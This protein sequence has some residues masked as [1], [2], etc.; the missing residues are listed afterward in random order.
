MSR[1]VRW[2][3]VTVLIALLVSSFHASAAH[4]QEQ[5]RSFNETGQTVSGRF[6]DYWTQ[7][8]GLM[9]QGYPISGEL[10][11][12]SAIDGKTYTVQYFERAVFEK[13]P[14]NAKP[15]DVLLSLLGVMRYNAKYP[16]GA[17]AQKANAEAGSI[18]FPE[19]GKR[20]GGSFLVYFNQYGGVPQQGL[21]ISDEFMERSDLDGK[22]R[23]V[24]YFERAV[25]EWNPDNKP[26]FNVLLAQLGTFAYKSSTQPAPGLLEPQI[27]A[28]LKQDDRQ[29]APM[30]SGRYMA[31]TEGQI[32]GPY[33]QFANVLDVRALDLATNQPILVTNASGNQ[34]SVALDGSLLV[35]QSSQSG[36]S[37]D[38]IED[39]IYITDLATG[40]QNRIQATYSDGKQYSFTLPV[41]AAGRYVAGRAMPD[42][43]HEAIVTKNVD[44][45]AQIT[46]YT[47]PLSGNDS[48][49][50]NLQGSGRWLVW[51]EQAYRTTVPGSDTYTVIYTYDLSTGKLNKVF[52]ESY[53]PNAHRPI[54]LY[55]LNGD[56][57]ILGD[58]HGT[59]K[60]FDLDKNTQTSLTFAGNVFG[61]QLFGN[62]LLVTTTS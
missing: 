30:A 11:E 6:L 51:T 44:S 10:Q 40:K 33:N 2:L 55:S 12:K 9:Q 62:R 27:P 39:G 41:A 36:C 32:S 18:L 3:Q 4:A 45:G 37:K 43:S 47:S 48:S 38:C 17:P 16:N 54:P 26:P 60:S 61:L 1:I 59:L 14:E 7:N 28:P 46:V 57:L 13:H 24:Q 42:A 52:E 15:Y 21:P 53:G 58:Q 8:G 19:T 34:S 22:I 31:W 50:S 56:R 5:T 23:V 20:V 25:F 29:Y 35:W 49:I